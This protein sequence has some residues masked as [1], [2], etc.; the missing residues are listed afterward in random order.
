MPQPLVSVWRRLWLRLCHSRSHHVSRPPRP[1][2]HGQPRAAPPASIDPWGRVASDHLPPTT[3]QARANSQPTQRITLPF[4]VCQMMW[5]LAF[6]YWPVLV[7][8]SACHT[9]PISGKL[10]CDLSLFTSPRPRSSPGP[11]QIQEGKGE[12]GLWA[13]IIILMTPSYCSAHKK[14][15][16][17]KRKNMG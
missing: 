8:V 10:S 2:L 5:G 3:H 12:F 16:D 4:P 14:Q 1:V 11:S 7:S 6:M 13:V 17:S 9:L 15:E